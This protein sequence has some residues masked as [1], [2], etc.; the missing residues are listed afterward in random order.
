MWP[1]SPASRQPSA[2]FAAPFA[3]IFLQVYTHFWWLEERNRRFILECKWVCVCVCLFTHFPHNFGRC[4]CCSQPLF[5]PLFASSFLL[6][7]FS[8]IFPSCIN[9]PIL[10]DLRRSEKVWGQQQQQQQRWWP[11]NEY[12]HGGGRGR[13]SVQT[14]AAAADDRWCGGHTE[15]GDIFRPF[16]LPFFLP[17]PPP[18]HFLASLCCLLF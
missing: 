5:G 16:C 14:A 10:A 4:C 2:L 13:N 1:I 7:V 18:E 9:L 15:T 17:L 8:P 3:C 11:V 12:R 6:S